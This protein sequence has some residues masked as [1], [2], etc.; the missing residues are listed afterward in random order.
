M[1]TYVE[2]AALVNNAEFTTRVEYGVYVLA[3]TILRDG[4][5]T[6]T[7]KQWARQV[8]GGTLNVPLKI[9]VLWVTL[10]TVVATSG[11]AV[12]DAQLQTVINALK[13]QILG[14]TE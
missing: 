1:A 12:T 14:M 9:L 8:L 4:A 7:E 11:A 6:A 5:A 10:A 2:L 3:G 13:N